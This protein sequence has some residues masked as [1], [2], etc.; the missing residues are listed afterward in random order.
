MTRRAQAPAPEHPAPPS[1]PPMWRTWLP[2]A[3]GLCLVVALAV[4]IPLIG[5]GGGMTTL[6]YSAFLKDVDAG[7]ITSVTISSTGDVTGALRAGGQFETTVPVALAGSSLLT[8]LREH[9]V[10][11]TA[12]AASSSSVW[13]DL[14]TGALIIAPLL[15]LGWF[16]LRSSRMG[17]DPGSRA[18]SMGRSTAK[19]FNA[20]S[21]KV[22]FADIAGYEGAKAEVAEVVDFL[23][24]PAKYSAMGAA[25][26]RGELLVG[27][28]GTGKTLL[29]RAVAGEAGVAFYSVAGSG[30]VEM[31]VGVGASRVRDLFAE[32]RKHTPAI[33]FIDEIDAIG[34]RRAG[35]GSFA[36]NDEREQTLNQL[37]AEMDGFDPSV[38]I[39][40]LAA[41]NRPDVL[42]LALLR[43]GRFDRRIT[44]PLPTAGER[45][46]ILAAHCK[47]KPL[48][49][50]TDLE[51]IARGTPGFS[52]ADL[53]NLANE[54]AIEAVREGG[55]TIA[56]RH[57][58]T[59]RDRILLGRRETSNILLPE[60]K[61]A[62]ATHE[63]GHALVA[64]LSVHADPVARITI[65]PAGESL[66]V[67]EQLPLTERH[68][69]P[70][71]VLLDS[72]TVALGGRAAELVVFDEGSTGAVSDL[73][74]ATDLATRM[75]RE[76]GLSA[77]VGPVSY[78]TGGDALASSQSLN[79]PF[80]EH[81]QALVDAEVARLLRE[82]EARARDLITSHRKALDKLS[83]LLMQQETIDGAVVYGLVGRP[84]PAAPPAP[85]AAAVG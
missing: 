77:A 6:S 81:T 1:P 34:G 52:G 30:F 4:L 40:V 20:S 25:A 69:H 62:V 13:S 78:P 41:T 32:A 79:R 65:L 27:P 48:A 7:K 73:A 26:P 76:F 56:R 74:H 43:P 66:G 9:N 17:S 82:A 10:A 14:V 50:G 42:D 54:A 8:E 57:F 38:G 67:T 70:E 29:A 16:F 44:V 59:A 61:R 37:L 18:M 11:I 60:E 46:L 64:A 53:A 68:L 39:V 83:E 21:P 3:A 45:A 72:L 55:T 80:A 71:S 31:F 84:V 22:T 12:Q 58:D 5:A 24:D 75:V 2:S 63:A 35:A 47:G 28:P 36:A 19:L 23:R 51:A 49:A 33:I 85:A 15:V